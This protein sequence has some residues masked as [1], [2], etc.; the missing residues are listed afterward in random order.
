M[1]DSIKKYSVSISGHQTSITL[2]PL[3]WK[4]L[5]DEAARQG[6]SASSLIREIDLNRGTHN[7]SSAI[8]LFI[9]KRYKTQLEQYEAN[10]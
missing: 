6:R 8:R 3:F 9:L 2:E 4:E 7:L 5:K 1:D 10:R